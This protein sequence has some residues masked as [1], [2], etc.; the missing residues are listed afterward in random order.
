MSDLKIHFLYAR[1]KAEVSKFAQS[2]EKD[3]NP[4]SLEEADTVVS[5]G[6]DGELMHALRRSA[7]KRVLGL[8]PPTS[9]SAGFWTNRGVE[10]SQ[11]LKDVLQNSA[12]YPIRPLR[13]DITFADGTKIE[14]FGYND[15]SIRSVHQELTEGLR[16]KYSLSSI[17]LGIQSAL[18][19]LKVEFSDAAAIGPARIMGTGVI[20]ST[21]LG[22]TAMNRHYSGPSIDIRT[23]GVVLT[24]MGTAEP[25]KGFSPIVNS[26]DTV[27]SLKVGSPAKRPVMLTFD[28]FGVKNNENNSPIA[29]VIV[30]TANDK[31]IDLVIIDDPGKRAYSS[32][33]PR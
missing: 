11:D 1:D 26:N 23:G 2:L 3:F 10:T 33:M 18:L 8:V 14:R 20:F 28:S 24:G 27:F 5:V 17:D 19:E 16:E 12:S 32:M 30:S 21:A 31:E 4:V 29:E 15:L 25:T 13:A 22:S 6:G 7:G 9:N